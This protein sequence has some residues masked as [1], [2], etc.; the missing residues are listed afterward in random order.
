[1]EELQQIAESAGKDVNQGLKTIGEAAAAAVEA[2]D[3][4]SDALD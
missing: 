2:A 1:M 3:A 4:T